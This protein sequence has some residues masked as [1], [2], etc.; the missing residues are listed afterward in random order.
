MAQFKI[1]DTVQ[2]KSGGSLMTIASIIANSESSEN[3][4][5]LYGSLKEI[6]P[7][8]SIFYICV[9][10]NEKNELKQDIFPE[11]ILTRNQTNAN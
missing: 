9:W 7:D 8:E 4:T 10:F 1:G 5:M 3:R 6:N 2:L 11:G